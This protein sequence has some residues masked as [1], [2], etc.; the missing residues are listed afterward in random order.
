VITRIARALPYIIVALI[1]ITWIAAAVI[2]T[3]KGW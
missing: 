1:L 2:A 3:A